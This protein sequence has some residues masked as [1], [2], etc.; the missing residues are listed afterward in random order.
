MNSAAPSSVLD[1]APSSAEADSALAALTNTP[2]VEITVARAEEA[3][4]SLKAM[5]QPCDFRSRM[6]LAAGELRKLRSHQE[7]FVN[8]LA[9]RLS[10]Y[11]RLDFSLSLIDLQTLSYGKLAETWPDSLH[12]TLFKIEPLRG[13]SILAIPPSLALSIVDR[14]MGGPG[15][16]PE[17]AREMSEIESALLDQALELILGEWCSHW[18]KFKELKPALLGHETSVRFIQSVPPETMMLVIAMRSHLGNGAEPL[19]F[20]LPYSSLEPLI[21]QLTRGPEPAAEAPAPASVKAPCKWNPCF[22]EVCVRLVAQWQGIELSLRDI[23]ALKVGD[24][25]PINGQGAKKVKVLLADIPKFHGRLGTVAGNWAIELIPRS[26][27]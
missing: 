9:A 21:R 16:P 3:E 22:D 12:L 25:L 20:C 19:Q 6:L 26:E 8:A 2:E 23:L 24:V 5:H 7:E 27:G 11:L 13:T 14:L 10:I 1:E 15:E 4:D 17:S 18:S